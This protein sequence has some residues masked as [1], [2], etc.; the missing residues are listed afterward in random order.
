[1]TDENKRAY[2]DWQTP[3]EFAVRCC[4]IVKN[5]FH[6]TPEKIIEPTCGIG[7][8]IDA[9]M[10]IFPKTDV[11][12][13][14]ISEEY[15][16]VLNNKYE[17][18][19]QITIRRADFL[20]D[21]LTDRVVSE[22][23]TLIIGNPPWVTNSTLSMMSSDN[24]PI[25]S[26][27]KGLR[28]IDAMTGESNFDICEWIILRALYSFKG[29]DDML[30]MLCKTSVARN[31]A[32]EL[33]KQRKDVHI[34]II[35]FDSKSVFGVAASACL[36]V[37]DYRNKGTYIEQ[38]NID[39]LSGGK[40]LFFNGKDLNFKTTAE[41]SALM[42]TC[43]LT[44]RQGVKHDCS[45]VMELSLTD[46]GYR[47]KLGEHVDVEEA[48]L[49]PLIK[50]S[51]SRSFFIQNSSLA[52]PMTQKK[53]GEDT[54]YLQYNAPKFWNYLND[55]AELFNARKSKIYLSAPRFALFGVGEYSYAP[56]KVAVSGFYKD[57]VFSLLSGEKP[58]MLDDTCYFIAFNDKQL[59]QVC[60]LLLNSDVVKNF[61]RSVAF[62][63][64]KR[65]FSKKVLEKLDM[66]EA[67]K[68]VNV[69]SL[70]EIAKRIGVP[71][72]VNSSDVDDFRLFIEPIKPFA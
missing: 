53:I 34:S 36:L 50:S 23:S 7:N 13:I 27:I 42:G 67:L 14:E 28:G 45:K 51:G 10:H 12:G 47:N 22:K 31:I 37:C 29:N 63:D 32:I 39:E 6:Y 33:A 61:Y 69:E 48:Y 15:I 58:I 64:N 40:E 21:M 49:Y 70:N 19:P 5:H 72:R 38:L 11:L 65:P 17:N 44:W 55:H 71:F 41:S 25:K 57:P 4:E 2:G 20:K 26:N 68:R 52:V 3:Y 16:D 1:M 46:D 35:N 59:A 30:A 54:T 60:M 66:A 9:A 18:D 56:F 62:L 43:Q 8:F 24:L